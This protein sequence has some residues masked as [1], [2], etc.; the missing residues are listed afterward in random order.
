MRKFGTIGLTERAA[1]RGWPFCAIFS[2]TRYNKNLA[3]LY[4]LGRI[5]I[6]VSNGTNIIKSYHELP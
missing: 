6:P 2:F 3:R 1:V 5:F 4:L